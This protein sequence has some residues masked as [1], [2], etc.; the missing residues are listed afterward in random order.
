MVGSLTCIMGQN[1]HLVNS[2]MITAK[3]EMNMLTKD[4]QKNVQCLVPVTTDSPLLSVPLL[5]TVG[6]HHPAHVWA[7]Q[8]PGRLQQRLHQ[9]R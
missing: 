8:R 1:F 9:R 7:Q 3:Q 4:E 6:I 5:S 2:N